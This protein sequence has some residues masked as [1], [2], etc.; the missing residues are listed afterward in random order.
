MALV[1]LVCI[2]SMGLGTIGGDRVLSRLA[3]RGI[4][5]I[6]SSHAHPGH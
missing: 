2:V 4:Q 6:A 3:F 1:L 5:S